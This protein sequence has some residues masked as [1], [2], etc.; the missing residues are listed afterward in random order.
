MY[1]HTCRNNM[2][3]DSGECNTI[4]KP[5]PPS[6]PHHLPLFST[7]PRRLS[8][9]PLFCSHA[10]QTPVCFYIFLCFQVLIS[11]IFH[12]VGYIL[13]RAVAVISNLKGLSTII[14]YFYV[15]TYL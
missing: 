3:H 14:F 9:P 15:S 6:P 11:F 10:S 12:S 7:H 4:I 2:L 1:E 5:H 8:F 13:V